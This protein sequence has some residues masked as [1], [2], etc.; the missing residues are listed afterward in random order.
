[1][2]NNNTII[3][4]DGEKAEKQIR[5][6]QIPYDY[7]SKEYPIEVLLFKFKTGLIKDGASIYIP[8]YQRDF[9]WTELEMS[10]FI[11]SLLLGVPI[12]PIFGSLDDK[13][14]FIEIIDGS[15]RIRTINVFVNNQLT[16]KGLNKLPALNGFKFEDL[17]LARQNK[18]Q[19]ISLR[20]QIISDKATDEIKQDIFYRINTSGNKASDS[21]V[22][23]GSFGGEFYDFIIENAKNDLFRELAPLSSAK[24]KR[25]D[26]QELVLRFFAYS[27]LGEAPKVRGRRFL[28]NY[29]QSKKTNGFDKT[30]MQS[31]FVN[32]LNFVKQNF[33]TGFAKSLNSDSTPRVR[34]EAIAVGTF[35][36]IQY[37]PNLKPVYMDWLNSKEFNEEVASDGSNNA[38][39]LTSR[40]NFVRDCLLNRTKKEDLTYAKSY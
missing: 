8:H 24:L 3:K 6:L 33:E 19:T 28:D 15:Q 25:G 40:V 29:L 27:E 26:D 1:M 18:F 38:G 14:G 21:E 11:E 22:R 34:F 30:I 39:R 13:T 2:A 12:Q 20:F 16:L 17:T 9:V 23:K 36:A 4:R 35:L 7:D 10:R 31:N 37:D 5:E 32:M